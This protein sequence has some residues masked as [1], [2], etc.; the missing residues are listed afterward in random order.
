MPNTSSLPALSRTAAVTGAVFAQAA[1]GV[2][3]GTRLSNAVAYLPGSARRL[4]GDPIR[5]DASSWAW[6]P[7]HR[8]AVQ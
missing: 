2:N 3:R 1:K 8:H 7:V 4:A 6:R 5:H